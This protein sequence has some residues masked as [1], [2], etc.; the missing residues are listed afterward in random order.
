MV[1]YIGNVY[2][3]INDQKTI[4]QHNVIDGDLTKYSP[5]RRTKI[6]EAIESI[7]VY[8]PA[9]ARLIIFSMTLAIGSQNTKY[10]EYS[11]KSS[12]ECKAH[13]IV[14]ETI[15]DSVSLRSFV[16]SVRL[17]ISSGTEMTYF[18]CE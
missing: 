6:E 3:S 13:D 9:M 11:S 4:H 10:G 1:R 14:I 2:A 5:I 18:A 17:S 8:C 7:G 16:V 15:P 12:I